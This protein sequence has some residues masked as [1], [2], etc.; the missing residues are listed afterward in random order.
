MNLLKMHENSIH[1]DFFDLLMSYS[2]NPQITL[3]TRFTETKGTLIDN[4]NMYSRINNQSINLQY[5][6]NYS[7]LQT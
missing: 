7:L 5:S 6:V 2:L 3:P 4:I 1:C